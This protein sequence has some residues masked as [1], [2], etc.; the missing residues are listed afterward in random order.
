[1]LRTLQLAQKKLSKYYSGTDDSVYNTTCI[2]ATILYLSK[3]LQY[4]D[5]KNWRDSDIDFIK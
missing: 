2:L 1:M 5:N 4:F 3:K